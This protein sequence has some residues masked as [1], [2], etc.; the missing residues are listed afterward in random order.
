MSIPGS[1]VL[2]DQVQGTTSPIYEGTLYEIRKRFVQD[3]GRYDM[4][5][6]PEND[7]WRNNPDNGADR[8]INDGVRL[9]DRMWHYPTDDA[10]LIKMVQPGEQLISFA[11]ARTVKQVWEVGPDGSERRLERKTYDDYWRWKNELGSYRG[12]TFWCIPVS[13]IQPG[14][15]ASTPAD[16]EAAGAEGT[17]FLFNP[18]GMQKHYPYRSLLLSAPPEAVTTYKVLCSWH[19]NQLVLD[20]D[21]CYWTIEEPNLVV[22][23]ARYQLE[24]QRH[25]NRQGQ[26]DF[27]E[28]IRRELAEIE[29]ALV[30]EENEGP[31]EMFTVGSPYA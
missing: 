17:D 3:T 15:T 19:S 26:M 30:Q 11:R 29:L 9:L 1:S 31:P 2:Y 16:L 28:P 20:T 25:R 7:D 8:W 22:M 12:D 4:V 21:T 14:Q 6:D 24:V 5:M 13:A 18:G 27:L 10:W 23:A